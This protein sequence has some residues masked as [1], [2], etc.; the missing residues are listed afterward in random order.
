MLND[1][2]RQRAARCAFSITELLVCIAVIA[3]L[4]ALLLPSLR[5]ARERAWTVGCLANQKSI[6]VALLM[7]A[8][9]NDDYAVPCSVA[10]RANPPSP[11]WPGLPGYPVWSSGEGATAYWSDQV[12][13]GQYA[14]STNG[15]NMQPQFVNGGASKRS[16]LLC[17]GDQTH[18]TNDEGGHVSYGMGPNFTSIGR[19]SASNPNPYRNM[20]RISS[21]TSP[22]LEMVI[23]DAFTER[24]G[25]G[26]FTEPFTF[27]GSYEPLVNGVWSLSPHPNSY[28]NWARR[29]QG[30]AN[31]L[32]LD[33]HAEFVKDL[34]QKYDA[35]E[36]KIK[37]IW[38]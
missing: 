9:A 22:Q 11:D 19:R 30:G 7:Y 32:F 33:A 38:E 16:T 25:P 21:R 29:H 27:Y 1:V 2:V 17:L 20:W 23:V 24:F 34:K 5:R 26:G 4:I 3:I 28:Y 36:L 15:N 10:G 6:G 12:L 18:E 13:L 8:Q 35:G 14:G 37:M 31:V